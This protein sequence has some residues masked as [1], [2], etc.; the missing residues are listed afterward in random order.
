MFLSEKKSVNSQ[1]CNGLF[2]LHIVD[3][4][5]ADLFIW[6]YIYFIHVFVGYSYGQNFRY[7]FKSFVQNKKKGN[8]DPFDVF[9]D[10]FESK[11]GKEI[12]PLSIQNGWVKVLFIKQL[13]NILLMACAQRFF[14]ITMT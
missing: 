6:T 13:P 5:T 4:L 9:W 10:F 12:L 11:R 3:Y 8:K 14:I 7:S 1:K 2:H